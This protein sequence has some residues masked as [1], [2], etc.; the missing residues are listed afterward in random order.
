MHLSDRVQHTDHAELSAALDKERTDR[1]FAVSS[2]RCQLAELSDAFGRQAKAHAAGGCDD[3]LRRV[4]PG[5]EAVKNHKC[6]GCGNLFMNDSEFCR[7]CGK[8]RPL[9]F[10]DHPAALD[11]A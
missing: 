8:T 6:H 7:M 4:F 11:T 10:Q 9:L 5:V 2:L 3:A 1:E